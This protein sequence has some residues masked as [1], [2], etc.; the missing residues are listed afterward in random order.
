MKA[1]AAMVV[2]A[3][4]PITVVPAVA[5]CGL[6]AIGDPWPLGRRSKPYMREESQL[7]WRCTDKSG[8]IYYRDYIWDADIDEMA[9][10][11]RVMMPEG[12]RREKWKVIYMECPD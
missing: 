7:K 10:C 2:G 8:N 12:Q 4:V 1:A 3:C 9:Y 11:E 5:S 6:P